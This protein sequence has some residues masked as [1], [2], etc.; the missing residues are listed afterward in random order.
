M[1]H[2]ILSSAPLYC[3]GVFLWLFYAGNISHPGHA[4]PSFYVTL[5][6]ELVNSGSTKVNY[7]WHFLLHY[8]EVQHYAFDY[9]L[10]GTSIV[11][12]VFLFVFGRFI[13]NELF[14]VMLPPL[15]CATGVVLLVKHYL[16]ECS[17]K[18][19]MRFLF[20]ALFIFLLFAFS[21]YPL[22]SPAYAG[23]IYTAVILCLTFGLIK[24]RLKYIIYAF[25]LA[26]LGRYFRGDAILLLPYL[27]L[28]VS[29]FYRVPLKEKFSALIF[30]L[31][32]YF[33][34]HTP[35]YIFNLKL[36]GFAVPSTKKLVFMSEY[37][38]LFSFN[39]RTHKEFF[40]NSSLIEL[41]I[42]RLEAL[43]SNIFVNTGPLLAFGLMI[44]IVF[45]YNIRLWKKDFSTTFVGLGLGF[46]AVLTV[47]Y[48][49]FL[50]YFLTIN[51]SS[52]VIVFVM[53]WFAL[54]ILIRHYKIQ[55]TLQT[56][57]IIF[58]AISYNF[59]AFGYNTWQ[60]NGNAHILQDAEVI[61]ENLKS[62]DNEQ[63]VVMYRQVW[64]VGYTCPTIQFVQVP[65]GGWEEFDLVVNHYHVTHLVVENSW[66]E[67]HAPYLL[68]KSKSERLTRL[69]MQT[70]NSSP[71][72]LKIYKIN[73]K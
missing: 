33:I 43:A 42:E 27:V 39:L 3:L 4:D 8:N 72:G 66:V 68:S 54:F 14:I 37:R 70:E 13:D 63:I 50:P 64:Q 52:I 17:H 71:V 67:D 24:N 22:E 57:G 7:V 44:I 58:F 6:R 9:W 56:L 25:G 34:V 16:A 40:S 59:L 1:K 15:L 28:C 45:L 29:V 36:G 41:L 18:E 53:T 38:D 11:Q 2:S 32:T 20:P 19:N 35:L 10:P 23:S 49:F 73:K 62:L 48:S 65:T 12:A 69:N 47:F 31:A 21:K 61:C 51:K 5:A 30:G 46:V 26:A 60:Q 55:R